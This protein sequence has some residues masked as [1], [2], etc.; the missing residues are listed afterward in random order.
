VEGLD[1]EVEQLYV[2]RS[3]RGRGPF[4]YQ[5]E[6]ATGTIAVPAHRYERQVGDP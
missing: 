1:A 4:T 5:A 2:D 3:W 6:T